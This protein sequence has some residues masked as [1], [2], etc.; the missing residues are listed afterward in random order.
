MDDQNIQVSRVCHRLTFVGLL[1]RVSSLLWLADPFDS[2][3]IYHPIRVATGNSD[4]HAET[5]IKKKKIEAG[6][7]RFVSYDTIASGARSL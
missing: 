6:V 4:I 5:R 7:I 1:S 2:S 3:C